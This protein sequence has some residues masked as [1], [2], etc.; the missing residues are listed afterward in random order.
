M[1]KELKETAHRK[2]ALRT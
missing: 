1:N 2:E